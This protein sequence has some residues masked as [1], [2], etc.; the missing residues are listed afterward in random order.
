MF[1]RRCFTI[2]RFMD[3][4]QKGGVS[5]Y[6]ESKRSVSRQSVSKGGVS[7]QI[8]SKSGE[9]MQRGSAGVACLLCNV[10]WCP[11]S[12]RS[13]VIS[14]VVS[15]LLSYSLY[16]VYN[17]HD[18]QRTLYTAYRMHGVSMTN[19]ASI[20]YATQCTTIIRIQYPNYIM[21][22]TV[23]Y[24]VYAVQCTQYINCKLENMSRNYT[25]RNLNIES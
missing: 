13:H 16:S 5:R 18:V 17:I 14:L 6:I 1:M 8:E 19:I 23:Q 9:S 12:A 24:T 21:Y 20:I 22:Y 10:R 25:P 7:S 2:Y 4:H 15:G 3:T 11:T